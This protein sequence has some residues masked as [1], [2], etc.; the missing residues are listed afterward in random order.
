MLWEIKSTCMVRMHCRQ[1]SDVQHSDRLI[2]SLAFRQQADR[3]VKDTPTGPLALHLV[4]WAVHLSGR[5]AGAHAVLRRA[6]ERWRH[7][8]KA[9]A[10]AVASTH[11][12]E[13]PQ[14]GA[15]AAYQPPGPAIG[16]DAVLSRVCPS[17]LQ[18]AC[19]L[20]AVYC[21]VGCVQLRVVVRY[22]R[23]VRGTSAR[24]RRG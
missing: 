12:R 4:K 24:V 16:A 13:P 6:A 2:K 3:W 23:R 8:C 10:A 9:L 19:V 7:Y 5:K 11:G 18:L 14:G 22:G 1:E 17:S 21:G 15:A 20:R